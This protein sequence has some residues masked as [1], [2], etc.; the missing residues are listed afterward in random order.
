MLPFFFLLEGYN[1]TLPKKKNTGRVQCYPW[2]K[3]GIVQSYPFFQKTGIVFNPVP[4]FKKWKNTMLPFQKKKGKN[5]IPLILLLKKKNSFFFKKQKI[6]EEYNATLPRIFFQGYPWKKFWKFFFQYNATLEKKTFQEYNAT[7]EKKG[8]NV[9]LKK[10]LEEYNV[11]YPWKKIV[12]LPGRIQC[13]PSE[14]KILEEYNATLEK[15]IVKKT[16][17]L[18]CYP[19][20]KN[21][22]NTMLPLKKKLKNTMY[23]LEKKTEG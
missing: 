21:W 7:L 23:T 17:S 5:T 15:S 19:W 12:L 9:P 14:K 22:K 1:A 16:G 20:K 4:F 10:K 6:L 13:Y 2:K 18:Q 11:F 8:Y 3:K